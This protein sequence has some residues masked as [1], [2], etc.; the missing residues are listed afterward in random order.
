MLAVGAVWVLIELRRW[1][2]LPRVVS[3]LAIM[4]LVLFLFAIP[5]RRAAKSLPV[6]LGLESRDAYLQRVEPTYE[7]ARQMREQTTGDLCVLSQEQRA[8][9]LPGRITRESIY[10][11]HTGYDQTIDAGQLSAQLRSAGFTHLLLVEADGGETTYDDTLNRLVASAVA[12]DPDEAPELVCE[13]SFVDST[14]GTRHYRLM[15]LGD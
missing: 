6:A 10:R 8:Y 15:R 3:S 5:L 7:I 9:Y 12:E 4:V 14:G 11:R 2:R 13:T 1:P